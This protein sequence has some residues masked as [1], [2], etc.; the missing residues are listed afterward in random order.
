MANLI[1]KGPDGS[2]REVAV[3][4]RLTSVGR[5]PE[6]DVPVADPGLPP[7][8]FHIH[9]DGRDYSASA[10]DGADMSVNGKRRA[11]SSLAPGEISV[12]T[13][14]TKFRWASQTP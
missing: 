9:F 1:V 12:S 3:V 8:A 13:L 10:H 11:V 2:E 5:D 7:T 4:K 6:N 14:G